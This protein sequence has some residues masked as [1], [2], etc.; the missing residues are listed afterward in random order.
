[1][2]VVC[3]NRIN[4]ELILLELTLDRIY[5]VIDTR[6]GHAFSG[7]KFN[8]AYKEYLIMNDDEAMTWYN[9]EYFKTMSEI[10]NEKI[11]ILLRK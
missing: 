10:R 8:T 9:S 5:E 1:M 4:V 6:S 3:I 2:K 11:N 7:R